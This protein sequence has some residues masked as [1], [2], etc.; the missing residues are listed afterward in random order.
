M[1]ELD[2]IPEQH[3]YWEGCTVCVSTRMAAPETTAIVCID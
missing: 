3:L 2:W 1:C